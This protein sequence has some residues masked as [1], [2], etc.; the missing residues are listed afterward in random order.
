MKLRLLMILGLTMLAVCV[1]T[2]LYAGDVIFQLTQ[3]Y[4]DTLAL[5]KV[6]TVTNTTITFEN[7]TVISGEPL[8]QVIAVEIPEQFMGLATPRFNPGNYAILS[9]DKEALSYTIAWGVF[10]VSTQDMA[11]LKIKSGTLNSGDLAAFQWYIN[12]GETEFTSE[13]EITYV[14]HADGTKTQLYPPVAEQLKTQLKR[15]T[16]RNR[17]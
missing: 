1:V 11:T 10:K 15:L 6:T 4:Q 9:L 12:T 13:G 5:G 7:T 17:H 2:P 16:L 14:R 8:P 3:G